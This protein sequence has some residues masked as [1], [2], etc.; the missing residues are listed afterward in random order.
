MLDGRIFRDRMER[1]QDFLLDRDADFALL[2]PSPNFLYLTGIHYEMRER[3]I[4]L[5]VT[6]DEGPKIVAP[7]FEVSTLRTQTW[8]TDFLPW[9][10]DENPYKRIAE[11]VSPSTDGHIAFFDDSMP[12]GVYWAVQLEFQKM[13]ECASL[14]PLLNKMRLRKSEQEVDLMM[15]AG[16]VI[17]IAVSNAIA[18]ARLGMTELQVRQIIENE[19]VDREGTPTFATVQFGENSAHPHNDSG[20]RQLSIGDVVLLDCGCSIAGYNTDM[21]RV[22]VVGYAT[23]EQKAVYSVVLKAEEAALARLSKG[24]A[25]GTADGIARKVIEEAGYGAA[26]THRLGHGIGLEVHEPPYLVHGNPAELEPGMTHSVEPG[27][28]LEG[29]FGIRIEDLVCICEDGCQVITYSPKDLRVI[30]TQ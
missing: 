15:R 20:L 11:V 1:I 30:D 26:F 23:D 9:A 13:R 19:I 6:P 16:H 14:S 2:T 3:L 12:L 18:K 22:A 29:K 5:L 8:I 24:L 21:T 28:Y 7:S 4:G 25:C 27:I 17:D 10:E